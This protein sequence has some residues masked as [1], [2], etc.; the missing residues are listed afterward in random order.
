MSKLVFS[1]VSLLCIGMVFSASANTI[2][3]STLWFEE[4]LTETENGFSGT[5]AATIGYHY[6]PGGDGQDDGASGGEKRDGETRYM[7]NLT[8]VPEPGTLLL[9]GFALAELGGC[10]PGYSIFV[11]KG[12]YSGSPI[13]TIC[14]E[15]YGRLSM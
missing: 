4:A 12:R 3:S 15:R 2:A 11:A 13:R 14:Q 5:I 6:V 8:P 10:R 9:Y 7:V 1:V